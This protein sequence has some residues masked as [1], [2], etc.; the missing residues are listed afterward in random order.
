L[1]KL[2]TNIVLNAFNI[3]NIEKQKYTAK[4]NATFFIFFIKKG[5]FSSI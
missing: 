3:A 5:H 4:K 2:L 1:I